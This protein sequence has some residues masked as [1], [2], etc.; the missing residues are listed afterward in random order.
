[1]ADTIDAISA[2]Y[3]EVTETVT[4]T[5]RMPEFMKP[6]VVKLAA[7][8]IMSGYYNPK[9]DNDQFTDQHE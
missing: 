8:T 7:P 6:H 2:T 1:M 5:F 3:D 9:A 4:L